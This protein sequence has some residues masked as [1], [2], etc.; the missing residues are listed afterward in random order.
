M[1]EARRPRHCAEAGH[2][3]ATLGSEARIRRVCNPGA[4]T[5]ARPQE[6]RIIPTWAFSDC[7][8]RR[9]RAMSAAGVGSQRCAPVLRPLAGGGERQNGRRRLGQRGARAA[10][11]FVQSR[12]RA[13]DRKRCS[14]APDP[15]QPMLLCSSCCQLR[16][17]PAGPRHCWASVSVTPRAR[18]YLIR[19]SGPGCSREP[20][21][22]PAP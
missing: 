13:P 19:S 2:L 16:C 7:P 8:Q 9:Q 11:G 22:R 15:P 5:R 20:C 4:R 6:D 3:R 18:R 1:R 10:V 12:T 14:R 21:W 17:H